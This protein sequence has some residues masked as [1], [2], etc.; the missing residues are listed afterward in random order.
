MPEP[1]STA[2]CRELKEANVKNLVLTHIS[3]RY[4]EDEILKKEAEEVFE[5]AI[6]AYDYLTMKI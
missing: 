1:H 2:S 6:I 5:G 4:K 3:T